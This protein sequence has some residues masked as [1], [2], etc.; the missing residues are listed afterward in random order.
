MHTQLTCVPETSGNFGSVRKNGRLKACGQM[1]EMILS[2]PLYPSRRLVL[3]IDTMPGSIEISSENEDRDLRLGS[4]PDRVIDGY[5]LALLIIGYSLL[6][7]EAEYAV[8]LDG[9]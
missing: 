1:L 7:S 8:P 5:S 6:I 9:F 3:A 2:A 4:S